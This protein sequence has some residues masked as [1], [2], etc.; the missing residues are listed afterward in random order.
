M[1][2]IGF[3]VFLA[4][5]AALFAFEGVKHAAHRLTKEPEPKIITDNG[6]VFRGGE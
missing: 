5:L 6:A 1:R 2:K 4:M 3:V